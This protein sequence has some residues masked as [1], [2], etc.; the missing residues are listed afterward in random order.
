MASMRAAIQSA[1]ARGLSVWGHVPRIDGRAAALSEAVS[2]GLDVVAHVEEVFFTSLYADVESQL[3]RGL[4][5]SF[6]DAQLTE[7]VRLLAQAGTAVIPNL[8]FVAMTRAQLDDVDRVLG[9]PEVRYL[10]PTTVATWK[11]GYPATRSDLERFDRRER[12]KEAVVRRLTRLLNDA[13]VPLF[14]G[15]RF[16]GAGDVP[17][18]VGAP[19]ARGTRSRR[20][21][22]Q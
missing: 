3:E 15:D 8:S 6:S 12:G 20:P 10:H 9:D 2:A 19:R 18:Q 5:P 16:V 14:S 11:T 7:S 1:H 13:R 17:R 22:S 21:H 4:V